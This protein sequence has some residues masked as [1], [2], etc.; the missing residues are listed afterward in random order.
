[1]AAA[2]LSRLW[3]AAGGAT[4][5]LDHVRLEGEGEVLPSSFRLAT[6]AQ[7][8]I[9]A[10]GLAAAQAWFARTG[11]WQT[12]A[13]GRRHAAVEF[14][15]EH[16]LTI[17]GRG[18][19]SLWDPIAGLY[20]TAGG[21]HVRLHTNF[22]HHRDAV[23]EVLGCF[24]EREAVAAELLCW[25]AAAF[26][27]ALHACG[28]VAAALRSQEEWDAHEQGRA[29][30]ALPLIAAERIGEA[31]ARALRDGPR[32]LS[33]LRVL[34]L[35]RIIA[36]PVAGRALATHGATVLRITGPGLPFIDWAVK[37]TGRG[38]L[39]AFCDLATPE[40]R[41]A[42]CDLVAGADIVLDVYRPG[43]LER[44][45]FGPAAIARLRPGIVHVS[46]CAWGQVGP[47]ADRRGFDSLVQTATGFNDEEGRAA[48]GGKPRAL[49]CQALDHGTGYLM[50]LAAILTRLRQAGEGGSWSVRLSL[51]RTGL[52]LRSLGRSDNGFALA[53]PGPADIADLL[54]SAISPFGTM[55]HVRHAARMERNPARWEYPAVPLGSHPPAWPGS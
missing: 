31:P 29:V 24:A 15:S 16:Y 22:A 35:T 20:E 27:D 34:D 32:P 37:D 38:K 26:E 25:D 14:R 6:M 7:A 51:A 1:M 11:Q 42:L 43:A 19:G 9:A 52:W 5:A 28:G 49:P 2:E 55:R 40:G 47:W 41:A 54:E 3:Q 53:D 30:A 46:L 36:G 23:C 21:G 10:V 18:P 12:V 44:L 50:A 13:V 4:A 45:G 39:S 48:G 17:D 8:A 33:G